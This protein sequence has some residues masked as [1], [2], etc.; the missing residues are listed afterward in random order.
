MAEGGN[1][2]T[3]PLPPPRTQNPFPS[4]PPTHPL[5]HSPPP[6]PLQQLCGHVRSSTPSGRPGLASSHW[7]RQKKM[8]RGETTNPIPFFLLFHPFPS[9]LPSFHPPHLPHPPPLSTIP[10]TPPTSPTCLPPLFTPPQLTTPSPFF[11]PPPPPS[12]RQP[13][14]PTRLVNKKKTNK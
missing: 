2:V 9:P 4:P 7:S 10:H 1:R 13:P 6:L 5:P 11:F 12:H 8:T 3:L 14:Q